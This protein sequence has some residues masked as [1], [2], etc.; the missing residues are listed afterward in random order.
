MRHYKEGKISIIL[1]IVLLIGGA[2]YIFM[3]PPALSEGEPIT[4]NILDPDGNIVGLYTL[5]NDVDI[6]KEPNA[7]EILYG[8]RLNNE[9]KRLLP[10]NVGAMMNCNSCHIAGGKAIYGAHYV[11]SKNRY[12]RFMPRAQATLDLK[13]RINGCFQRSMNGQPLHP[14][15][16]EMNAM[17]AYME[18]LNQG[19]P[20]GHM[21]DIPIAGE[22]DLS[23]EANPA[24]GAEIYAARCG[25]CH[26]YNGEGL[27]DERGDI[28]FPPLW[29][30]ESF[31]I[32]AGMARTYKAAAFIKYAM[33]MS[34]AHQGLWGQGGELSDQDAVDVAEFFSHMPR[35]DFPPKVNDWPG[36]EKP[37]D[38]RY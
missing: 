27:K 30:D 14:D 17:V 33:P 24:R 3:R 13:E 8:K 15:S 32:G 26:G 12:P 4:Y 10:D 16:R 9:T 6:M 5:P 38:A 23:L 34:V 29:G 21:V 37:K 11:N 28:I 36:V 20:E 22:I 31:N 2:A 35:P 19:V 1:L 7:E 25:S 18:W